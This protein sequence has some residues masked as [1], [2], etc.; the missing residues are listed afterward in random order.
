[1]DWLA[2][3]RGKYGAK[4]VLSDMVSSGK[5][6]KVRI[7]RLLQ[8]YSAD[9]L[10]QGILAQLERRAA[11]PRRVA[12][13]ATDQLARSIK[14]MARGRKLPP[15]LLMAMIRH[16]SNFNP[17]ARSKAGAVGLMQL[18][19]DAAKQAG[20]TITN[21]TDER[22][23]PMR[24]IQGGLDYLVWLRDTYKIRKVDDLLG[25]YNAGPGRLKDRQYKRIKE[26]TDYIARVKSLMAAYKKEPATMTKDLDKLHSSL[27]AMEGI[28]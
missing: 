24:N 27:K 8:K 12:Y 9:R 11:R 1:M 19:P 18:M 5:L 28:E 7:D 22:L 23:E 25:A 15:E 10:F 26:T 6:D 21:E 20:L 16:E 3:Q 14:Q 2:E 4:A 17:M 13:T